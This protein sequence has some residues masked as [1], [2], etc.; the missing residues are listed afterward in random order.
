M[1][2]EKITQL[3]G[4]TATPTGVELATVVEDPSGVPKTVKGALDELNV[5]LTAV[6]VYTADDTWSKPSGLHHVIVELVAGGG[7]GG[8]VS[9]ALSQAAAAMS[10]GGGEYAKKFL[11]AADLA[12]TVAVTVGAGGAGGAAGA[13]NGSNGGV[14]SFGAHVSVN[15]GVG[16]DAN[17]STASL[18]TT[19]ST[20]G[21][22][23]GTGGTGGDIHI[24]G[25][26]GISGVKW[27]ASNVVSSIGG[28]SHLSGQARSAENSLADENG[29]TGAQYGG[30]GTGARSSNIATNY[31]GGAGAAG[32]V[33]VY[34]Y[35]Y[36]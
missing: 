10:G 4:L 19:G 36:G 32:V 20:G 33:I 5:K 31:A 25:G 11:L 34:E 13:N 6:R 9:S 35:C 18:P 12:A 14:S 3:D 15:G 21:G 27:T 2:D 16:G 29:I 7:G 17:P 24:P 23:G 30:G 1:T 28:A 26:S 8:G 22:I